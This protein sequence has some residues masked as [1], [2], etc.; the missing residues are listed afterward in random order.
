MDAHLRGGTQDSPTP[1]AAEPRSLEYWAQRTPEATALWSEGESL[2]YA[3]WNQAADALADAL[4]ALGVRERS[5]VAVRTHM[6][7]DWFIANK[8]IGKLGA[9]HVGVNWRLTP[10]EVHR[11]LM[12]SRSE[13]LI[14]DDT[15]PEPMRAAVEDVPLRGTY[16]L[17]PGVAE[18][19]AWDEALTVSPATKRVGPSRTPLF[20][21]TSGTSGVPKGVSYHD[22]APADP[23]VRAE[24]LAEL[25]NIPPRPQGSRGLLT[26]PL[27]HA[28][29]VLDAAN[30]LDKGGCLYLLDRFDA[31]QAL[32]MISTHRIDHWMGVPTMLQRVRS[33]P[34]EVFDKYDLGCVRTL[35]TGGS[36]VAPALTSWIS[37]TFGD[38]LYEQYGSTETASMTIMRPEDRAAHPGSSGRPLPH[39][40]LRIVDE[41]WN[42]LPTGEAGDIAVHTPVLIARYADQPDRQ[43]DAFSPDGYFRTGDIGHLDADGYLYITGRSKD[44]IIAGGTNIYPAEIEVALEDHPD[45][46]GSAVVGIP[47]DDFGEQPMAFL[48]LRSGATISHEEVIEFLRPR[49]APYKYPR[50]VKVLPGGLPRNAMGK[51]TKATLRA[52]YW[53][54]TNQL[55]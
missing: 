49:L 15:D 54:D 3:Q 23:V 28:G 11:Q 36:Q 35:Y 14:C 37:E 26:L 38:I 44:V 10:P 8:A 27:H 41:N 52:P 12:D 33:L 40:D 7:L 16:W 31:E 51:V 6:T 20:L 42:E 21:Y 53:P 9:E 13:V 43:L 4:A 47:H 19:A 2:T 5:R 30:T 17:A 18:R 32:R 48:E 55:A 1:P 39:V 46:V 34:A 24:Y 45:I 50:Q 29:G 22:W 25:T